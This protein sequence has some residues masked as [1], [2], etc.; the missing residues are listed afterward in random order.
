MIISYPEQSCLFLSLQWSS[1]HYARSPQRVK[2]LTHKVLA[3][4]ILVNGDGFARG[5]DERMDIVVQGRDDVEAL[6]NGVGAIPL[7]VVGAGARAVRVDTEVP[8]RATAAVATGS[9]CGHSGG[10]S[11]EDGSK[12]SLHDVE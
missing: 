3:P 11:D 10:Q 1:A 6:A 4:R 8:E 9:I 5:P 12:S 7:E 2:V